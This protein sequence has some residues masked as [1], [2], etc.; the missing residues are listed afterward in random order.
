MPL[1]KSAN[2][3]I[4]DFLPT[5]KTFS[6]D[7]GNKLAPREDLNAASGYK[8]FMLV[9]RDPR[10]SFDPEMELIASHDWYARWKAGKSGLL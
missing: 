1:L 10:G 6:I 8:S 9:D 3:M 7:M 5:L 2:F 4:D